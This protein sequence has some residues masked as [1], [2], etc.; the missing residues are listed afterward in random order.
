MAEK[1][2]R[3]SQNSLANLKLGAE[4]RRQGKVRHNFTILPETVQWLKGTG[5]ASDAIDAL[6]LQFKNNGANSNHTHDKKGDDQLVSDDVYKRIDTLQAELDETRSQLEKIR[7][8]E[9][10]ALNQLCDC[11]KDAFK[12]ADL[13]KES[14]K[15][16]R[17][18]KKG[19]SELAD[20]KFDEALALI[21]DV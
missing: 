14:R 18:K 6:V 7:A 5:N 19:S 4:T 1:E 11:H 9:A 2:R 16:R 12:A 20:Q 17:S 3:M 8:S 13:L 21:D 10:D 15:I